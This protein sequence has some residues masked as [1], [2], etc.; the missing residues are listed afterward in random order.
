MM[1]KARAQKLV[2][3]PLSVRGENL[4][5]NTDMECEAHPGQPELQILWD[6]YS[7]AIELA[8]RSGGPQDWLTAGRLYLTYAKARDEQEN[9]I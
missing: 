1:S 3:I 7:D 8:Q 4:P 9:A 5:M 2:N 6:E